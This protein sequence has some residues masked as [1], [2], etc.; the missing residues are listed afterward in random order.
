[1]YR[2]PYFDLR[3]HDDGELAPL[4]QSDI[5]ER[6]TLHEWPLSCVQRLALADGRK[7]IY[8]TQ[9]GP[10]VESE[11]YA[12]AKSALLP[13]A[14]TIYAAD[15]HVCMLIEF[16]EGPRAE[17]LGLG[18]EE[19]IRI[20]REVVAHIA[21]IEGELPHY[22]DVGDEEKWRALIHAT[23]RDLEGLVERN[24]FEVVDETM[25]Q[26][27]E[28]RAF[29]EMVLEVFRVSPGNV[30][31]DLGGDNLFVLPDAYR[32]IDWRRPILGPTDLDVAT[33]LRSL[34]VDPLPHV[35]G[36]IVRMLDLLT[37]HWFTQ[38]ATRWFPAG[39]AD[40]DGQIAELICG[41][42]EK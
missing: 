1:M 33:L 36:G 18:E 6:V 41:D 3:L 8:K 5:L 37:V 16:V 15:G 34:G 29:S 30:H 9:F 35:G 17:E 11:F 12:S 42:E 4:V 21:T 2:H 31:R 20:S 39:V 24:A 38:A 7:L 10:T 40:Y 28:E 22:L 25:I 26:R 23:L 13:W 32:V 19:A 27:L 14:E